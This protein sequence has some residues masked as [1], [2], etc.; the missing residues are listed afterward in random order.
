MS[1]IEKIPTMSDED[2]IN[3]LANARRLSEAGDEK[4]RAA[5]AELL[6]VL[7]GAAAERKSR[8]LAAAQAKRAANRRPKAKAAA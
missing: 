7:E 3:L 1:L 2:V 5:A 6:P 4:Q 8:R